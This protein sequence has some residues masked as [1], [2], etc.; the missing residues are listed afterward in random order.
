MLEIPLAF[1][2]RYLISS[3]CN[4]RTLQLIGPSGSGK[5]SCLRVFGRDLDEKAKRSG[6][7]LRHLY[8]NL[9]LHEGSRTVLYRHLY[10]SVNPEIRSIGMSPE[11]ILTQ[12][13]KFLREKNLYLILSLDELD[14]WLA[15]T[16]DST[17]IYDLTRL[18]EIDPPILG[19]IT[20]R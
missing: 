8:I 3:N 2:A 16:K 5:T 15:S 7:N 18:N 13:V 20:L 19:S 1:G 4:L 6:I 11:E 12:L 17:I 10:E 9:K 14:Y